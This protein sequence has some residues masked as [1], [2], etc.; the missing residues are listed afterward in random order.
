MVDGRVKTVQLLAPRR[1]DIYG[2]REPDGRYDQSWRTVRVVYGSEGI[3]ASQCQLCL[4]DTGH[5]RLKA[6]NNSMVNSTNPPDF[7]FSL[8]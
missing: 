7:A 3:P 8:L 4:P 1:W 5:K 6:G 2:N